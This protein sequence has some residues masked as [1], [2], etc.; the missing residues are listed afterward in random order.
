M[1]SVRPRPTPAGRVSRLRAGLGSTQG[2][3]PCAACAGLGFLLLNDKGWEPGERPVYEWDDMHRPW[4]WTSL[5]RQAREA[6]GDLR[7]RL[8]VAGLLVAVV[9]FVDWLVTSLL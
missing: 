3:T 1:R 2:A 9:V 6:L 8:V 4:S 5:K 7:G